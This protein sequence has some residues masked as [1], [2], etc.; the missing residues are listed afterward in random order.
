MNDSSMHRL[1]FFFNLKKIFF[2]LL[3]QY[4][5]P[6]GDAGFSQLFSTIDSK[7]TSN[8]QLIVKTS[9]ALHLFFF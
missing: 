6:S 2:L 3:T 8:Q 4:R 9:S 5:L 7:L 1:C